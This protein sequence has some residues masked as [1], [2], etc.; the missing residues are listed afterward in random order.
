MGHE[1][2]H[3]N[4]VLLFGIFRSVQMVFLLSHNDQFDLFVE[5]RRRLEAPRRASVRGNVLC[6]QRVTA[7]ESG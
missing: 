7:G 2:K 3:L 4:A 1:D 5:S 6:A